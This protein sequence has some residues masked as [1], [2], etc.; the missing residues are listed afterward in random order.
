MLPVKHSPNRKPATP[1]GLDPL[2]VGT[3]YGAGS[4]LLYSAANTCLRAVAHFDPYLVS[5]VKAMPTL[6]AAGAV[7]GYRW[8]GG[9]QKWPSS[10]AL[11]TLAVAATVA[12]LGGNGAFQWSLGIIGLAIAVPLCSGTML[13]GVALM[14]RFWLGEGV[15]P[16]TALAMLVL[17]VSIIVL[18]LGSSKNPADVE[19]VSDAAVVARLARWGVVAACISGIAYGALNVTIRRLVTGEMPVSIMLLVVSSMGVLSLG[20]GS[21]LHAGW[22]VIAQTP[23]T[24]LAGSRGGDHSLR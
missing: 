4:A 8:Y 14:A 20:T 13:I 16:R 18:S 3:F 5:C 6:A 15:T 17:I 7:V 10:S 12:Q 9:R 22:G 2:L 11:V 1:L 24:A 19:S 23:A 21:L